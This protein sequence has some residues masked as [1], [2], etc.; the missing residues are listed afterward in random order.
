[1]E[2]KVNEQENHLPRDWEYG[3]KKND[4]VAISV[5]SFE[6]M[7]CNPIYERLQGAICV[8]ITARVFKI[9]PFTPPQKTLF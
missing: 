2:E 5:S 8:K 7:T 4:W 1:M 9:P 3:Y 6:E